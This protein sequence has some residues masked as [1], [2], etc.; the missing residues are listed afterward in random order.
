MRPFDEGRDGR[1]RGDGQPGDL[2]RRGFLWTA[3]ALAGLSTGLTVGRRGAQAQASRPVRGGILKVALATEPTSLDNHTTT[4]TLVAM[5]MWHVYETLF[6]YDAGFQSL[7]LLARSHEV[8]RDG[9][10]HTI[11]LREKVRFHNGEELTSADVVASVKRWGGLS[12]LGKSLMAATKELVATDRHKVEFRLKEP[13]STLVVALS[14]SSQGCAIYP[15]SV[16]DAAGTG[17]IKSFVGTG[18][19]QFVE[20]QADRFIRVKRYDAYV[21]PPGPANGYGGQKAQHL[22]QIDFIPV[23]DEAARLAGLKAGDFH[24]L[25]RFSTDQYET[26][27][28]ERNI[29]TQILPPVEW[30]VFVINTKSGL[31]SNLK[32][33]QAFQAALDHEAIMQ[34]GYG[35]GFYRLDPSLMFKETAWH[36]TAGK[37]LYNQRD[38]GKAR[39]LLGEARYDGT[40]VRFMSTQ[41]YKNMYNEAIV[42]QQNLESAGF[43]VQPLVY[44][45]PTMLKNRGDEKAWDVFVT[46]FAFRVDPVALPFLPSC[47]WPGWWCQERK[48]ALAK[49]L[50]QGSDFKTRY[51]TY[52]DIQKV[53]YEDVPAIK[54]GD[55][56]GVTAISSRLKGFDG[57]IQLEPEFSNVWLEK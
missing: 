49:Q 26:L 55:G 2:S 5:T 6:T 30:P 52:E 3:A 31:M 39:T 7:P 17:P 19:Y 38:P 24:Y 47:G 43:K 13:F 40:P 15:K 10:T 35:K 41:E 11:T 22:D 53:F 21:S 32:I 14:R 57:R 51:R 54:V 1:V 33:R 27:K 48:V 56:L 42:A 37:E 25:E 18:P 4:D 12:S 16:I 9:L 20:R 8:S 44:D 45:W 46:G 29:V 36:S 23:P 50:Q 28:N 34:A